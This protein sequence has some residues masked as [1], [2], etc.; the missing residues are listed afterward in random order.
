MLRL[1]AP[2]GFSFV[3]TVLSHGWCLLP[4]FQLGPEGAWLDF[5]VA[6]GRGGAVAARVHADLRVTPARPATLRAAARILAVDVDVAPLHARVEA[7]PDLGWIAACGAGRLLRAPTM[8]EDLVKL[9]LTTNCSW[10]LTVK[11]TEALVTR[12]GDPAPD[13]RHAFPTPERLARV[14]ESAL[15]A[16]GRLGYRAPYVRALAR[17]VAAGEVDLERLDRKELLDLPGVGPY[18]ADNL[19]KFSGRPQGL[20]LDSWMRAK[21]ARLHHGGR[22]VSDQTIARRYRHLDVWAGIALWLVLTRDWFEGD[23]PSGAWTTLT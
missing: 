16:R 14:P 18:V 22:R 7:D 21:Y 19:L 20:G 6:D 17:R 10:S 5:V 13:G 4:P 15:R 8:W 12:W 11:M 3:R 2:P 1:Q 23:A 9:V